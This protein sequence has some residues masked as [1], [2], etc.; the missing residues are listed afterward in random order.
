[1]TPQ[2]NKKDK[3]IYEAFAKFFEQPSRDS[4]R[5]LLQQNIGELKQ[6]DF[7]QEW[8]SHSRLARS[9]LGLANSGGGCL[10]IGVAEQ[11]DKSLKSI[12]LTKLTDKSDVQKGLQKFLSLQLQY[13]VIDFSFDASEYQALIG[14]KFQAVIAEDTPQYI[15]FVAEA[16]GESIRKSAIYIRRGT[17]TEEVTY[18]ELQDILNRRL[19]TGYS[20]Q[21][22]LDLE[23]EVAE[24][25]FLYQQTNSI[26]IYESFSDFIRRMIDLKKRRIQNL[27]ERNNL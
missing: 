25:R 5:S 21:E 13:D 7:K 15:P 12:G 14:K 18:L 23:K 8:P 22:E 10:V 17:N 1:M 27:V 20:S 3:G 16:D 24:L 26:F 4:L 2:K 9:V 19:E 6:L 11:E